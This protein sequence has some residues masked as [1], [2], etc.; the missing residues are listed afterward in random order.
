M[1]APRDRLRPQSDLSGLGALHRRRRFDRAAC[2]ENSAAVCAARFPRIKIKRRAQ[3]TVTSAA[4]SN[5]ALGLATG[6]FVALLDH[7][8]EL[9]PTALY[10]RR[11]RDQTKTRTRSFSIATRTSSISRARRTDP[12]FKPDWNPD[13]FHAQNYVSHLSVYRDG[14][15]ATGRRFP[16]RLRRFAGLR[17]DACAASSGSS[18]RRSA[19]FRTCSITGE[20]QTRAPPPSPPRNRTPR[21]G[22]PRRAGTYRPMR[23]RGARRRRTTPITSATIYAPPDACAARFD[24]HSDARPVPL[25]RAVHREHR[26]ENRLQELR[27]HH[28]G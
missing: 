5:D 18:P 7:D 20:S 1:A 26:R 14:A 13:L 24:H 12:Y 21:G 6:E 27:D 22:H 3:R 4:A 16:R 17:P 9:A 23:R 25:L 11:A 19:T 15:R 28:R 2:L 8:D 10:L